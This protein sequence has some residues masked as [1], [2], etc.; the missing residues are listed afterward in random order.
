MELPNLGPGFM[1]VSDLS[2]EEMQ[3]EGL[4][5]LTKIWWGR[6]RKCQ[7]DMTDTQVAREEVERTELDIENDEANTALEDEAR[8][9]LSTE[10]D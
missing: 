7:E 10:G 4:V 5:T 2:R 9:V 1:I 8:D 6:T 3:V